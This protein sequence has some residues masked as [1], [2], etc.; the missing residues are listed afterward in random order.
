MTVIPAYGRDYTSLK[1]AK[2]DWEDGKDFMISD[3]S[4]KWDG[5]YCSVRNFI[6]NEVWVR[7]SRLRKKGRLQ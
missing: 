6:G 1:E 3:V 2:K 4:S 7:Y 5:T